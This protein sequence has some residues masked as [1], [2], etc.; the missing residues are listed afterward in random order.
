NTTE[1]RRASGAVCVGENAT[2][3]LRSEGTRLMEFAIHSIK[4]VTL[5]MCANACSL[6]SE[7]HECSS[8]EYDARSQECSIHAEDGQPFG[9]SV[10]TKTDRPIAFFQQVCVRGKIMVSKKFLHKVKVS[11]SKDPNFA[12]PQ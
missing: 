7:G 10:L 2:T 4:N 1:F 5:N 3:Y 8:F 11:N 6:R 9:A 12:T